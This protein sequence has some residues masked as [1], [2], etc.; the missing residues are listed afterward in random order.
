M[1]HSK[2]ITIV[3]FAL[4]IF[5]V[6]FT[7]AAG[8]FIALH[9]IKTSVKNHD[10]T[11][12]TKNI[13]TKLLRQNLKAQFQSIFETQVTQSI[14]ENP[15][16]S[17][18]K[19]RDFALSMAAKA[20]DAMIDGMVSPE[21]FALFLN[22]KP[23]VKLNSEGKPATT[24]DNIAKVQ[25]NSK[26]KIKYQFDSLNKFYV[27]KTVNGKDDVI[28]VLTRYGVSWKVSNIIFPHY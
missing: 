14:K 27:T 3:F 7:T 19:M 8:P 25:A 12:L 6:A 13:D 10:A 16:F 11:K 5:F 18:E 4:L 28:I 24:A 23:D 1:K 9:S 15:K 22:E 20:F 26:I 2:K 21:S 17:D